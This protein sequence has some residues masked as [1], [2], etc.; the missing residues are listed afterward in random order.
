MFSERHDMMLTEE[1]PIPVLNMDNAS[2][3]MLI[4]IPE[5]H[6]LTKHHGVRYQFVREKYADGI[7]MLKMFQPP[8]K[9]L[10]MTKPLPKRQFEYGEEYTGYCRSRIQFKGKC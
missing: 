5:F 6:K 2:A 10:A 3:V 9:W 1:L 8:C 7:F 4:K